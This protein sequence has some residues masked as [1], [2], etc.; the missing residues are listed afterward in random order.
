MPKIP[1][2]NFNARSISGNCEQYLT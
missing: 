2:L 1:V